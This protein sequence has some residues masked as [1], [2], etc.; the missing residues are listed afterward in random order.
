MTIVTVVTPDDLFKTEPFTRVTFLGPILEKTAFDIMVGGEGGGAGGREPLIPG[1][2]VKTDLEVSPFDVDIFSY[3]GFS[4]GRSEMYKMA[5][6]DLL[7]DKE[8]PDMFF[9]T[10]RNLAKHPERNIVFRPVPPV[11]SASDSGG[12][13]YFRVSVGADISSSGDVEGAWV[14]VTSGFPEAD[15][16]AL[17]YVRGW[18][19]RPVEEGKGMMRIEKEI[20]VYSVT[21]GAG[22]DK[23]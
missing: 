16:E 13:E 19:F 11:V 22:N 7:S 23:T 14:T 18:K 21:G 9:G 10:S 3:R 8:E 20:T 1:S 2:F 5:K 17:R 12:K 4:E 6:E 15:N